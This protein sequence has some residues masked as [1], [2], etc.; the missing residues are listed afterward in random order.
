MKTVKE[1]HIEFDL[2]YNSL[3]SFKFRNLEIYE[4]DWFLNKAYLSYVKTRTDEIRSETGGIKNSTIRLEELSPLQEIVSLPVY[5]EDDDDEL[6]YSFLPPNYFNDLAENLKYYCCAD[7][8]NDFEEVAESYQFV[9]IAFNNSMFGSSNLTFKISGDFI[10]PDTSTVNINLFTLAQ[11]TSVA[12]VLE[13][14]FYLIN[15][16][17]Q[18]VN[19]VLSG[20]RVAVYWERFDN[21]Y[22]SNSFIFVTLDK[23]DKLSNI[24]FDYGSGVSDSVSAAERV[25]KKSVAT[26]E[27]LKV[28]KSDCRIADTEVFGRL[29][30]NPFGKSSKHSPLLYL[31]GDKIYIK[32]KGFVPLNLELVFYRKPNMINYEMNKNPELGT[33]DTLDHVSSK[34]V[35]DACALAFQAQQ[36]DNFNLINKEND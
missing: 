26:T 33:R 4:I 25:L 20:T 17:L 28:C 31:K 24:I 34:I 32:S 19:R 3:S 18:E 36:H 1:L 5:K 10:K 27:N 21:I 15:L 11:H 9:A 14:Q 35:S 29:Q 13:Y 22:I 30:K 23:T 12:V 8:V 2:S 7:P 6:Y 16:I